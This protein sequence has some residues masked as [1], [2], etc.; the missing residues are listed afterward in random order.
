VHALRCGPDP[1]NREISGL[2]V[3]HGMSEDAYRAIREFYNSRGLA[4]RVGFGERP[5][6]IAIDF[7]LGF[8]DPT[9][10]LAGD[11]D[12]PLAEALRVLQAARRQS[13]PVLFTTVEYDPS[14]RDAGLFIHKVPSLKWLVSGSRWVELDPRLERRPGEMLIKKKYASSFFGTDLASLLNTQR[15][16]TL[17][18]TGCTTSGCVRATVVDALQYGLHAIVPREAVGD[19]ADVPHHASLFDMDAKYG[20]VMSVEEVLAYLDRVSGLTRSTAS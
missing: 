6:V 3:G 13:A 7:I 1:S 8:T 20:D 15:V 16:D 12:K 19:R 10:P 14:F 5:A 11:L 9:S 18:V 17:I 2:I 4:A